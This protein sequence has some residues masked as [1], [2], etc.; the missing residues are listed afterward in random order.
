[1]KINDLRPYPEEFRQNHG[2]ADVKEFQQEFFKLMLEK[3]QKRRGWPEQHGAVPKYAAG[4][5]NSATQFSK[6]V[7]SL[8]AGK[9]K[10]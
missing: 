2:L 10:K 5:M 7:F 9:D 6:P 3:I 8:L 4:G 1:M